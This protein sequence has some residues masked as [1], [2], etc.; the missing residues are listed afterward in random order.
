MKAMEENK[1]GIGSPTNKA[2]GIIADLNSTS[3]NKTIESC[4]DDEFLWEKV[5]SYQNILYVDVVRC[6]SI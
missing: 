5:L 6:K 4:D 3:Q 2:A 1:Q